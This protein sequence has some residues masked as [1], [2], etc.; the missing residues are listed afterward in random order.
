MSDGPID[1]T[2]V[3]AFGIVSPGW[4]CAK[5]IWS[6]EYAKHLEL[7]GYRVERSIHK[8]EEA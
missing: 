2:K 1:Q 3:W 8:P 5:A 4:Y 7:L 6:H